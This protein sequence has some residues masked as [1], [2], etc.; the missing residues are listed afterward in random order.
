VY[1]GA[2]GIIRPGRRARFSVAIRTAVVNRAAETIEYGVGSGIVWDSE[3]GDEHRECVAKAGILSS[4]DPEFELL[5]TMLWKPGDGY[6]L[7]DRHLDRLVGAAEYFGRRIDPE[8]IRSDLETRLESFG[9]CSHRVRLLVAADGSHRIEAFAL[10]S[11]FEVGP[12]RLGLACAAVKREDPFLNFKTTNRAVYEQA[13][14]SR[15]D[16]EDVLLWS[17]RGEVT[18]STIANLVAKIDGCLVTPPIDCGLLAGTFRADLLD[19]GEISE[20]VITVDE[21]PTAEALYLINS[22]QGWREVEWSP[23]Q[24]ISGFDNDDPGGEI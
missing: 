16:C 12:V 24:G 5:E 22:V 17:D 9:R 14:A 13:R 20:R 6:S 21:L 11:E 15:L 1:T 7:L 3:A 8:Q 2:I 4:P 19:R 10:D 18:E 23:Q